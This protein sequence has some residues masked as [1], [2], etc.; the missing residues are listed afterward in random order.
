MWDMIFQG[1]ALLLLVF[2]GSQ[3]ILF[4]S[5]VLWMIWEDEIEPRL[6]PSTKINHAAEDII[7]SYPDPEREAFARHQRAWR[8]GDGGQQTYLLRVRKAIRRRLFD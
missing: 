2:F 6:I 7:A 8:R 5:L 4:I 3:L 1:V